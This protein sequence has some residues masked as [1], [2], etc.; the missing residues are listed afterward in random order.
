MHGNSKE[1]LIYF[2]GLFDGEGSIMIVRSASKAFMKNR[3]K[4]S[5]S[6]VARIGMVE[7]WLMEDFHKAFN[8][9]G[10][11]YREKPYHHKRPITRVTIRRRQDCLD[12]IKMIYPYLR[13]K[14]PQA[15]LA[16]SFFENCWFKQL[17]V[18][19][20]QEISDL[21]HEHYL[22]MRELNGIT[23]SPAT[24]ERMG[25]RGRGKGIRLE[26]TV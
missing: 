1:D 10:E 4:P 3:K 11:L 9:I 2:G 22:K 13:L 7:D 17:G 6:P 26:T 5:Y 25:K 23:E 15:D 24:T 14:K 12:F 16:L 18:S 21:Q 8:Y 20:P 19:I